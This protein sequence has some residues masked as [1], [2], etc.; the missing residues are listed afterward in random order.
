MG[1]DNTE[2]TGHDLGYDPLAGIHAF[3]TVLTAL[4]ADVESF[5]STNSPSTGEVS[6]L[7]SS[8]W[9]VSLARF[10]R[11]EFAEY[12]RRLTAVVLR[13]LAEAFSHARDRSRRFARPCAVRVRSRRCTYNI[14][15]VKFKQSPYGVFF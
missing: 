13:L 12:Q 1:V 8:A 11:T 3:A 2:V 4:L 6:R 7:P 15:W 10:P 5:A 9:S 14:I